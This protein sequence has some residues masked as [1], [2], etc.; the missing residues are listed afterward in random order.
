MWHK[1]VQVLMDQFHHVSTAF[2][3]LGKNYQEAIEDITKR[4]G[5]RMA[6]FICKEVCRT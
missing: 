6:K 2:L 3:E 4:M 5:A 1:G